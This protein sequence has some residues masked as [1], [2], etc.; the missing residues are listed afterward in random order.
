TT[1]LIGNAVSLLLRHPA[2]RRRLQDDPALI[3]SAVEECLRFEPPVQITD[4]AVVAPTEL[5]GARLKPG[6][7]VLVVLA[8]ANRDPA[9]FADPDRFDV[10]RRDNDHLSFG[11]GAHFC[12]GAALARLETQ[13]TLA[14]LLKRFPDFRGP[15]TLPEYKPSIVLRGPRSLALTL[16]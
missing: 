14:G 5:A 10:G 11:M 12:L 8:S 2:E 13:V 4:R 9:R 6:D 3:G 7:L 15:T 1:N 16:A